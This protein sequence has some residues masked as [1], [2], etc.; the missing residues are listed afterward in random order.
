MDSEANN[1]LELYPWIKTDL[2]E[3]IL[4]ADEANQSVEVKSFSIKAALGK[5]ENFGSQMLRAEVQYIL[6]E[7]VAQVEKHRSLIIKTVI[8]TSPE[9]AIVFAEL[10]LFRM[11]ITA[12]QLII[13]KVQKLLLSIGDEAKFSA[14]YKQDLQLNYAFLKN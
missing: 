5:G 1:F 4:R 3:S 11:E 14:K 12:Y 10:G 8:L 13:P 6:N 7:S 9:V 2:F